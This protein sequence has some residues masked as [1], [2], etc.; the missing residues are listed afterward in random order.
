LFN[1]FV[2][3]HLL[4]VEPGF[5]QGRCCTLF[6]F[7]HGNAVTFGPALFW[8][9]SN[10]CTRVSKLPDVISFCC[11]FDTVMPS[12]AIDYLIGQV[13]RSGCSSC[14]SAQLGCWSFSP[15]S[16]GASLGL[17]H[18]PRLTLSLICPP[19]IHTVARPECVTITR[20]FRS[21]CISGCLEPTGTALTSGTNRG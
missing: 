15:C 6:G 10:K 17:L 21:T 2:S 7:L 5:L 4:E 18:A 8:I 19:N 14:T 1:L 16:W 9:S 3:P 13:P 11:S 20:S 12:F